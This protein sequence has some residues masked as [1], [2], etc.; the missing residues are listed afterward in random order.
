MPL[1]RSRSAILSLVLTGLFLSN[2]LSSQSR[3][4]LHEVMWTMTPDPA[5]DVVN[6][7][8]ELA[9]LFD[10]ESITLRLP[11]WKPGAYRYANYERSILSLTALDQDGRERELVELDPRTWRVECKDASSLVVS[12]DL[13]VKDE[14]EKSAPPAV[15]LHS[16]SAF[17]YTEDSLLLPHLLKVN[18][19]EDWSFSSGHRPVAGEDNL[20][21]SPNYDV[22]VD[23]PIAL[24]DLEFLHFES[25]GTP[26]EIVLF[27]KS[28]SEAQFGRAEWTSK[29][30]AICE[31]S[32]DLVGDYPF[33]RY[34]FLYLFSDIGGYYGL[35]HLNSTTIA[36]NHRNAKAGNVS[37]LESVSAH[38]F[39]HL[40]N[41]KRI[42]PKQLGPF[43]YSQDV[44]TKDLWWLE[45]V[46]SYY[47][48][49]ILHRS[50]LRKD[51][52]FLRA[53]ERNFLAQYNSS[54]YGIVSPER[55][56]WTTWDPTPGAHISYYDQG[57]SLGLL[58]DVEIRKHTQNR[59]SLDDVVRFFH[60]WVDYPSEGYQ[61]G[62]LSRAI[63]AVTGWDCRPF[64]EAH[65]RGVLGL[66]WA[67]SMKSAGVRAIFGEPGDPYLGFSASSALLAQVKENSPAWESGLRP[68]DQILSLAGSACT[69]LE[70]LRNLVFTL[71][72]GEVMEIG[73]LREGT[74][75]T[76][77]HTVGE[78]SQVLFKLDRNQNASSSEAA[79]LDGILDGIPKG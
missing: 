32:W 73:V 27:G 8:M 76:I 57:Q 61:P 70:A 43:D 74:N 23:C 10:R 31:A 26:F 1:S 41:V 50:G 4:D 67:D 71:S 68:G 63:R 6:M 7:E 2:S 78:R 62:D 44:R 47:T 22:F 28:P 11:L 60:H 46:T 30:K 24:G 25:H 59:R 49:V 15:H 3:F 12:Y 56:S 54:G 35:E 75:M 53:Q 66:P 13:K 52:W 65:V 5:G 39:F 34:V 58:L 17:L 38:E 20:Y 36:Y 77:N 55:S 9:P 48:D 40:W 72:P 45:G 37:G 69:D 64:F 19:P 16:P 29:V 21:R 18:L 33:E 51:G 42:R 79:I 14:S